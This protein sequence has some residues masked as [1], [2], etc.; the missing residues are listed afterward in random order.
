METRIKLLKRASLLAIITIAYNLV[1]VLSGIG[2]W[3]MVRRM[4]NDPDAD[5]GPFEKRALQNTGISSPLN[6]CLQAWG[7]NLQAQGALILSVQ[8]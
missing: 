3:N 1:E 7:M 2:I 8:Y 4:K 6:C 5:S